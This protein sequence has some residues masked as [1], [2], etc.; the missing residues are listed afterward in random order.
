MS[1]IKSAL[2]NQPRVDY[3]ESRKKMTDDGAGVDVTV[4]NGGVN[5]P[6]DEQVDELQQKLDEARLR[7]AELQKKR[8]YDKMVKELQELEAS[9]SQQTSNLATKSPDTATTLKKSKKKKSNKSQPSDVTT[10]SLRSMDDVQKKVDQM[11]EGSV[12]GHLA[13][14]SGGSEDSSSSSESNDD[15]SSLSGSASSDGSRDRS[16]RRKKKKK[17]RSSSSSSPDKRRSRKKKTKKTSKHSSDSEECTRKKKSA[18]KSHRSGKDRKC[19]SSVIYPQKWPHKYLGQHL[20]VKEKKYEQLSMAEFCAGYGTILGRIKDRHELKY[21]TA[22]FTELMYLAT[23]FPWSSILTY[24]GACLYEVERGNKKWSDSFQDLQSTS[25]LASQVR[26][27]PPK[28]S[29]TSGPILFCPNYQKGSCSYS[30]DHE[31]ELK[32]ETKFLKHICANCWLNDS[33]FASH[34]ESSCP[35]PKKET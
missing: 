10:K 8:D 20:A 18:R 21:R 12:G 22:H 1:D 19:S 25:L 4:E 32:G 17:V 29:P 33:K 3:S 5:I 27:A 35:N 34:P 30:K 26:K 28:A 15:S 6:T 14:K 11:M 9:N 7:Q 13:T 2:R 16:R 31:G 24:H 23:R